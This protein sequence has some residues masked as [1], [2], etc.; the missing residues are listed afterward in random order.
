MTTAASAAPNTLKTRIFLAAS[1]DLFAVL[2]GE[3]GTAARACQTVAAHNLA[4]PPGE[5]RRH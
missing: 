5:L 3:D 2:A 4:A 1:P